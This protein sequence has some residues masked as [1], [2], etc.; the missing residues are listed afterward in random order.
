MQNKTV[1]VINEKSL[2]LPIKPD[3]YG[4]I[5]RAATLRGIDR[6]S[7]ILGAAREAAQETLLDRNQF[8]VS[9][10][11]HAEFLRRLDQVPNPNERLRKTMQQP[12][13]WETP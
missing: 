1:G 11:A 7:F 9:S 13:P 6:I 8:I 12:A 2:H 3:D 5:D 4:L 10:E